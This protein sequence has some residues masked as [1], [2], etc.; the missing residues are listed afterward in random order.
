MFFW[1]AGS[2]QQEN[3]F[4]QTTKSFTRVIDSGL[5]RFPSLLAGEQNNRPLI[6]NLR[7]G[8]SFCQS[9]WV[10]NELD[11]FSRQTPSF[12]S[13]QPAP[14]VYAILMTG[15]LLQVAAAT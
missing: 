8:D 10:A 2:E 1:S 5:C 11:L 14:L 12:P 6:F 4:P 9:Q 13:A 7:V 3:P 15:L